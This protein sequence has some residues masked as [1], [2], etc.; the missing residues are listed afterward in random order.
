MSEDSNPA[1][2]LL[3]VQ[4]GVAHL[5]LNRPASANSFDLPAAV[6]LRAA[7]ERCG[8]ED[9]RVVVVTGA[10]KRFCAGGDVASF[11]AAP[12]RDEY[13]H[14]LATVLGAGLRG[15]SDLAKPVVAGVHGAVAGAGLGFVLAADLVVADRSTKF[16]M[17]FAGIG[18]TPDSGVSYLLPRVIGLRRA[19]DLTLGQRVI[20]AETAQTWDL[21]SAVVD[22]GTATERALEFGRTIAAGPAAALGQ[23]RRLIRSGLE[24]S[25]DAHAAD[26]ARTISAAV[27]GAEATALI[28]AF[29]NR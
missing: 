3:T 6:E 7:V 16:T 8:A 25:R 13:I 21:V 24:A 9:V 1:G 17:A 14:E 4:D 18:L 2:V 11:V 28:D 20:D 12:A 27:V 26:E 15:L 29:V 10:G 22:D 5:V 19:L 23:A